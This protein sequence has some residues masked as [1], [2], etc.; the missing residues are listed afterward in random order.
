MVKM[1]ITP[2]LA[3]YKEPRPATEPKKKI[4]LKKQEKVGI[5]S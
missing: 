3:V 2:V 1:K 5:N 4:S